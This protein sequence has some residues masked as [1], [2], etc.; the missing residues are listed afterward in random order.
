MRFRHLGSYASMICLGSAVMF[1]QQPDAAAPAGAVIRTETRV[2]LVDAVVTDKKGNYVHGLAQKDFKV[3]EDNK[4]QEITSFSSESDASGPNKNQRRYMVLFFDN[5]TLDF[6]QQAMARKAAVQFINANAGPNRVMS[7]VNYTGSLQITQNFTE[8]VDKLKAAASGVKMST[9]ASN[10]TASAGGPSISGAEI[11]FGVNTGILALRSLVKNLANVP[12]RKSLILLTGGFR[13]VPEIMSDMTGLID[14]CNKSN[15]AIY[16]IDVRGLVASNWRPNSD[17]PVFQLASFSVSGA[18]FFQHPGGGGGTGGGSTGGGAGSGGGRSGGT[19]GGTTGGTGSSGSGG[20]SGSTGSA[21]GGSVNSGNAV[22]NG[23]LNQ[24]NNPLNNPRSIIPTFPT[25]A[26]DNQQP[27]YMLASGT[28]GFVIV[29]TNDLAGGLEKIGQEQN[30]YYL[31]GYTPTES[32][33]GSCHTLKVKVD[34]GGANVRA[35]SGYCNVKPQDLLAGDS[36]EK[37]LEKLAAGAS[38]GTLKASM[39]VPFF[40]TSPTTV[41]ADMAMEIP[42]GSIKFD[43]KK[44]KYHAVVNILGITYRD[45]KTVAARFSDSVKLD[46]ENKKEMEAFEERPTVHYEKE[47]DAVPGTYTLKVVFNSGQGFGR[48]EQPLVIDA[49]DAKK[50][51]VSS[52]VFSRD[53]HRI[54]EGDANLDAALIEDR[55]PLTANGMEFTPSGSAHFV[56][57]ETIALFAQIYEGALMGPNPPKQMMTLVQMRVLDAKTM[58]MKQDSGF[59]KTPTS[60]AP[61]SALIPLA[62]KV[63]VDKLAAGSY[64][65]E[66]NVQDIAGNK[67]KRTAE[68][69]VQ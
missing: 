26:S 61:G 48:L 16:P 7:I 32:Q 11:A 51:R 20:K 57:T 34:Q 19:S 46:F 1:A 17:R 14:I 22:N 47:F 41:R 49:G 39:L 23:N 9:V 4:P 25:T 35:R 28:G 21:G 8:D 55:T 45:D 37:D 10:E 68:F 69:E 15:V 40:Y 56:R 65:L 29:N 6:G 67:T 63:P 12:G 13:L 52:L 38:P 18:A 33:E 36:T 43:K 58:E 54:A 2:V 44:G 53:F 27:L 62:L 64:V 42:T 5:S 66:L 3:W 31:I 59:L 50:L 30:E 60:A 24:L